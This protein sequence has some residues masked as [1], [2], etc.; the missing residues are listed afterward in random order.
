M[1]NHD[2][3]VTRCLADYARY[4]RWL[5]PKPLRFRGVHK[6]Q[7]KRVSIHD[8]VQRSD[9]RGKCCKHDIFRPRIV[10]GTQAYEYAG[11]EIG[12]GL[13]DTVNCTG[14]SHD[15]RGLH[16]VLLPKV[17]PLDMEGALLKL[18]CCFRT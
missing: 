17:F 4:P 14:D 2:A 13:L 9:R 5:Q 11:D 3:S 8:P 6:L 16:D 7:V 1:F 12:Q 15:F 10:C 18:Y